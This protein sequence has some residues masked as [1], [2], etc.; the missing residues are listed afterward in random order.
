MMSKF[1]R[2]FSI[3]FLLV[4]SAVGINLMFTSSAQAQSTTTGAITGRVT[5]PSGAVIPN[6]TVTLLNN[7]TNVSRTTTASSDGVYQFALLEPGN[8]TVSAGA[9]GFQ[10]VSRIL[11]VDV[12]QTSAVDFR[13]P[14]PTAKQMVTV[15]TEATLIQ[16]TNGNISAT[17]NQAQIAEIPNPGNDM[18]F[19]AQMAPGTVSNSQGGFGNVSLYGLPATSNVF[20]LNGMND[21]DPS[22]NINNSGATNLLLGTNEVA[23]AA[24][25]QNGYSGEYG[26]LA[27]AS[28]NYV[29][30][31]E[32]I[33][34]METPTTTG[35]AGR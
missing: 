4:L 9:A 22:F 5:D 14:L 15:T 33:S 25:V 34:F 19:I 23:E 8:Y 3:L 7:G 32:R 11:A 35:M 6:A 17:I 10:K 28:I 2:G 16:T 21:Q 30:N 18:T 31:P 26:S 12:G 24:V 20:T 29:T 1:E 13:L 27:G